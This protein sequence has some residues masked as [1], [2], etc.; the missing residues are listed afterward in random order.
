[1]SREKIIIW[2][3][4]LALFFLPA[5][6]TL[7]HWKIHQKVAWLPY[8]TLFDAI[9]VTALFYFKKTSAIA[10]FINSIF[11]IIGTGYHLRL[12]AWSDIMISLTD[13]FLGVALYLLITQT[14]PEKI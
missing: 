10:L 7:I 6:T 2:S 14:K 13:F 12:L 1:M 3:L 11:I 9:A 8:L 4:L 5:G